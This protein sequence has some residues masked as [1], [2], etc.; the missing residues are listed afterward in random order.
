[1]N[2]NEQIINIFHQYYKLLF[3]FITRHINQ[4][5]NHIT[6]HEV[7]RDLLHALVDFFFNSNRISGQPLQFSKGLGDELMRSFIDIHKNLQD[8][9]LPV[10]TSSLNNAMFSPYNNSLNTGRP[11]LG[12]V[13]DSIDR[14]PRYIIGIRDEIECK[15]CN[16][17]LNLNEFHVDHI[18]PKSKFPSSHLWNLQVLCP[19]CNKN[20]SDDILDQIPLMLKGAKKRTE[21][22]FKNNLSQINNWMNHYYSTIEFGDLTTVIINKI[23]KSEEY[24]D[25][26]LKSFDLDT[27]QKQQ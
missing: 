11:L 8:S 22:F 24:W 26:T 27:N 13:K 17:Q 5:R 4:Q 1:M 18:I 14:V 20:K 10:V 23:I 25:K 12:N 21:F 15:I 6:P 19:N 3:D 9:Y 2:S 7:E 16:K